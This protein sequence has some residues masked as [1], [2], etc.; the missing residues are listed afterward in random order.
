MKHVYLAAAISLALGGAVATL[1][2]P[3]AAYDFGAG[4]GCSALSKGDAD[5]EGL[6]GDSFEGTMG[7][8]ALTSDDDFDADGLP[9]SVEICIC[10]ALDPGDLTVCDSE[11]PAQRDQF[12]GDMEILDRIKGQ[13]Y[14]F[15]VTNLGTE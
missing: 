12:V 3:A 9:D 6:D 2:S 4:S 14:E 8:K 15:A 13:R 5:I 1:S 10:D 7:L 11:D